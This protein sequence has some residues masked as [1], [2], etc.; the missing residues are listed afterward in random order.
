MLAG[1]PLGVVLYVR[2]PADLSAELAA[3]AEE[4]GVTKAAFTSRAIEW[5]LEQNF[6]WSS[7]R[8]HLP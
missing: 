7:E 1:V 5:Y 3:R 8:S 4:Y 6:E 2:I